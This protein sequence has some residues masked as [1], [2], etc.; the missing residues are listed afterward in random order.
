[1]LTTTR[2]ATLFTF[3]S[4]L[5][6]L[7]K[8]GGYAE[9]AAAATAFI[10]RQ[11]NHA[12]RRPSLRALAVEHSSCNGQRPPP[13]PQWQ[14]T[15]GILQPG[16]GVSLS[17]KAR[18]LLWSMKPRGQQQQQLPPALAA[19]APRRSETVID[20]DAGRA[21]DVGDGGVDTTAPTEIQRAA[22]MGDQVWAMLRPDMPRV[23]L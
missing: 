7:Q 23:S 4:S 21:G 19:V 16:L 17:R 2:L 8:S 20:G 5:L 1:M 12:Q 6:C 3:F 18:G 13:S 10:A 11:Q 15:M 14:A 9:A 22:S